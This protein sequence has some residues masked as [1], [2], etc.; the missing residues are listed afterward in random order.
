MEEGEIKLAK[1]TNRTEKTSVVEEVHPPTNTSTEVEMKQKKSENV[2]IRAD[3]SVV[4]T[5]CGKTAQGKRAR[6]IIEY[7]MKSHLEGMSVNCPV[8]TFR[9]L[10]SIMSGHF[11]KMTT[12]YGPI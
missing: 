7:H 10:R 2:E 5:V 6:D 8:Y 3:G 11:R 1:K 12:H 9:S 4:C